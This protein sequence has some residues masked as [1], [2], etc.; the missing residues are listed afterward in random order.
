MLRNVI[1]ILTSTLA[2]NAFAGQ[3]DFLPEGQPAEKEFRGL[4]NAGNF[5]QALMAWNSAHG[6]TNFGTSHSG[7]ATLAYLLYQ[8]GMTLSG[9]DMVLSTSPKNLHPE[10]LKVWKTEM[11]NSHWIQKGWMQTSG[12]WAAVHNN[13]PTTVKIKSLRDINKAF[14]RAAALPKDNV[15]EKARIWWQIA[16]QAPL[17]NQVDQALK[18]LK[19]MRESGQTV[20]GADQISS[21]YARALYQ[22]GDI[23]AALNAFYEIP[24]SSSLWIESVEERAWAHLRKDDYDKA[25]GETVTLLSPAMAPLVGPESYYLANLLS[26]KVCDYPRIF[27]NSELFKKRHKDRLASLQELQKTGSNKNVHA[28]FDRFD[29]GGV[30]IEAAGP[31]VDAVPRA[32]YRDQR[33]LRFMESR[34][35]WLIEAQK[36]SDMIATGDAL[37]TSENVQRIV[38][39]GRRIADRLRQL[40][41]QRVRVLAAAEV[42]EY[43]QILNKMHIVEGEVIHRLAVDDSLKGERSK[44]SKVEDQGDVLVFPYKSD[45]VWFDELDNYKARVKDCPSLKKAAL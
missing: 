41:Y 32:T 39:D 3:F 9:L 31:L 26:L 10:L 21:T 44:L 2:L 18:A 22:K 19:L 27:K 36:A 30:T 43:R 42:K 7:K 38:T 45:E 33:F 35:Q 40:A 6:L 25:L 24:K 37:G 17:I 4:M 1:L 20:V 23:D 15:N 34:R 29:R 11:K 12:A 16:T 28:I 8:N 14:A 5:K 13:S